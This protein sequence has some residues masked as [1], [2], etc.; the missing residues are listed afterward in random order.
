MITDDD[1]EVHFGLRL[2]DWT[3]DHA[4]CHNY[5]GVNQARELRHL[6]C[7]SGN[8]SNTLKGASVK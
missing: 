3:A 2:F 8:K 7:W 4:N 5:P 6:Q 1:M